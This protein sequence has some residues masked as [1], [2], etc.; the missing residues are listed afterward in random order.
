MVSIASAFAKLATK[1]E[2]GVA[3]AVRQRVSPVYILAYGSS[4]R[5]GGAQSGRVPELAVCSCR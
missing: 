4:I 2:A 5:Y 1:I 3:Q